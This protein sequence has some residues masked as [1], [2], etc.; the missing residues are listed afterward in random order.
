MALGALRV[1]ACK[2]VDG[3]GRRRPSQAIEV[4]IAIMPN[5]KCAR[6]V[7]ACAALERAARLTSG[8][9]VSVI[10][11]ENFGRFPF[12]V[13]LRSSHPIDVLGRLSEVLVVDGPIE[14]SLRGTAIGLAQC[15]VPPLRDGLVVEEFP[16]R[17]EKCPSRLAEQLRRPIQVT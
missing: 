5:E 2:D 14:R 13:R 17:E 8:S 4:A 15:V 9:F 16:F 6:N 3:V 11:Y 12:G 10:R 7:R 1:D